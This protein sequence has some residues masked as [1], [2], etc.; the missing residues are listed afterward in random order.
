MTETVDK[1]SENSTLPSGPGVAFTFIYYFSGASLITALFAAKTL[2]VGFN[3]GLPGQLALLIGGI[4]GLVGVF[5]NCTK[6]LEIPFS[7]HK[8]LNRQ[9]DE[10]LADMGYTLADTV[11]GI[12]VYQRSR[13]GRLFSGDIYLQRQEQFVVLVSRAVNIR[14]LQKRLR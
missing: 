10:I 7:S 2:G 3:T 9:L 11:D 5:Y 13:L 4:S 12:S 8:A 14:T 1:S 6:T